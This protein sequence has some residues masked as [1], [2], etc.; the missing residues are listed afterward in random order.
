MGLNTALYDNLRSNL[1]MDDDLSSLNRVYALVLREERHKAM[2]RIRE[3]PANEIAM[4]ARAGAG[5]GRGN[6]GQQEQQDYEPPRCNHCNKWYH[7]EENCWEKLGITGRGRGR[8]KRGGR[9][10]RGGRGPSNNN[11]VVN[12]TTTSEGE[13][14]KKEFT[15]DE[16]EQLRSLL[17]AKGEGPVYEDGDWTG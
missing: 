8:G 14:S 15:A 6:S 1:L 9:G 7:T 13:S 12:A 16:I 10:G 11:Q 3:E 2:T 17:N 4:T 5:R